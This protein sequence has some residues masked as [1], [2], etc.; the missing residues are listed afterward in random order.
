[1]DA[2]RKLFIGLLF[3][4]IIARIFVYVFPGVNVII[5]TF[6][7]H[8][9][10][11]GAAIV[12]ALFFSRMKIPEV[13]GFGLGLMADEFTLFATDVS[14]SAYWSPI[15]VAT[16]LLLTIVSYHYRDRLAKVF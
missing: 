13:A 6:H 10:Y 7:V 11:F 9:F 14:L 4:I 5:A 1:M 12:L 16:A 8:H 15:V 2:G 3:A